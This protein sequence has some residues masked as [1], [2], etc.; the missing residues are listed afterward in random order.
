MDT[1]GDA[2]PNAVRAVVEGNRKGHKPYINIQGYMV[3]NGCTD[4]EYDG[5]ALPPFAVGKSLISQHMYA[6]LDR[7]CDGSFYDAKSDGSCAQRLQDAREELA[8]LNVYNVL[9][10]CHHGPKIPPSAL[11]P[12]SDAAAPTPAGPAQQRRLREAQQLRERVAARYGALM[13]GHQGWPVTGGVKK[14][15]VRNWAQLMGGLTHNPPCTDASEGDVWLND[16]RVREALHAA[17]I[18]AAGAP[19]TICR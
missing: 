14:G 18:D 15:V 8:G 1:L 11:N 7:A 3:G 4:E 19:W 16:P 9:E 12:A 6:R 5:N 17:P 10:E 13:R 2:L